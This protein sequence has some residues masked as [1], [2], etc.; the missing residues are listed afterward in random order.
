MTHLDSIVSGNPDRR[1]VASAGAAD[2]GP[3]GAGR[4]RHGQAGSM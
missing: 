1:P 3:A 2:P 4:R